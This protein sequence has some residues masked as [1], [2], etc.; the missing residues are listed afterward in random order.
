MMV[1]QQQKQQ[2]PSSLSPAPPKK[3]P[4]KM[5]INDFRN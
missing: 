5:A 2:Q 4:W 1:K 3:N